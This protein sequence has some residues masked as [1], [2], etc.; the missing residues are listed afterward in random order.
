MA[1][2]LEFIKSVTPDGSS[3]SILITDV[4]SAKYD[5]YQVTY[6]IV[7]DSGSPKNVNLRLI[8][9]S[10][11]I[12][13]NSNYD[14]AFHFLNTSANFGMY[15]NTDQAQW[16]EILG[17]TDY[18]PEG[19]AGTFYIYNPFSSSTY[20]FM[21]GQYFSRWN[22]ASAGGRTIGV[23]KETTSCTGLNIYLSSTNPVSDS[24]I[25]VYGVKQ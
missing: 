21:A 9:S 4:F 20:T 6:S 22:G 11:A 25:S 15:N 1:T 12:I 7:T 3:S 19:A 16:T 10:D 13:T 8:N 5:T 14:Y 24:Y 23:L 17:Y 2:N 18:P